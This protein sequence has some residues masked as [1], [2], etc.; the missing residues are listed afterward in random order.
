MT[1]TYQN[2]IFIGFDI[3]SCVLICLATLGIVVGLVD[4]YFLNL[5]YACY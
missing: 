1:Y 5:F 2:V 4:F 3:V